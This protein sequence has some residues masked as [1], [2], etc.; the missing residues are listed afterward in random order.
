MT[1]PVPIAHEDI[2]RRRVHSHHQY[3]HNIPPMTPTAAMSTKQDQQTHRSYSS[4]TTVSSADNIPLHEEAVLD[5]SD[6]EDTTQ[7]RRPRRQQKYRSR[8]RQPALERDPAE[9]SS[10]MSLYW[11]LL[12]A[13]VPAVG[14]F[15]VGSADVWA[16]ALFLVLV[17]YYVY[18]L[19]RSELA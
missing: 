3:R 11:P 6:L 9:M 7:S 1:E 13:V 8:T 14:A 15:L 12:F 19:M 2:S 5:D 16:D 10:G 18:Q 4:A 17:L